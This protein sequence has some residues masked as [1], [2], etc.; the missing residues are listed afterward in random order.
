MALW[1][2]F[3]TC[4]EAKNAAGRFMSAADSILV[5]KV[6]A[7][8]RTDLSD[9]EM[10]RLFTLPPPPVKEKDVVAGGLV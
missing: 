1:S 8:V 9:R 7:V 2:C 3:L 5:Q 4:I 6:Q 10:P